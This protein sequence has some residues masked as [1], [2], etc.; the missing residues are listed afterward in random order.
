MTELIWREI[1]GGL[2]CASYRV[3]RD[4]ADPTRPWRLEPT[5]RPPLGRPGRNLGGTAHRSVDEA[6]RWA[7]SAQ[8]DRFRRAVAT[9]HFLVAGA[10][11]TSFVV[12]SQ[13]IGDLGGLLLVAASLYLA[14]RSFGNGLGVLLNDAW[15]W[16]RHGPSHSS[17][18]EYAVPKCVNWLQARRAALMPAEPMKS[19]RELAPPSPR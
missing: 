5:R 18:L 13:F 12:S 2:E 7:E 11:L 4:G 9:S 1:S 6:I 19:V 17:L 10:A 15:G 14:L 8:R 3:T 16:T